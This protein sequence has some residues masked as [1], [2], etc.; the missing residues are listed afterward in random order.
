LPAL[1]LPGLRRSQTSRVRQRLEDLNLRTLG[2][3]ASVSS[4]HL[5]A[6]LGA[7]ARLLHDWASGIDPSPVCPPVA[8]PA[9]EQSLTLDPDEVDDRLLLGRLYG[10][11]EQLCATLRQQRR[12]CRHISLTV[13]HSD[14]VEQVAQQSLPHGTWWEI[15]LQPVL[16]RLFYRCFRRRVRLAR[17][18]LHAS[19]LESPMEQLSLFDEEST[20]PPR[21]HR[22]SATLDAIR[23]KF[24]RQALAWGKTL[25]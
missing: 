2:A 14:H 21:P 3:I 13:R 4:A 19:R 12:V 1:W 7:A 18:T 6:A 24:G 15:D 20:I 17:M 25:Q 11:L 16:V 10:L 23:T 22:L 9:L 5:E 8:Q